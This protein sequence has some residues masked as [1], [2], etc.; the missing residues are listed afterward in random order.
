[1]I[2]DCHVHLPSPSQK[3]NFEWQPFAPDLTAANAEIVRIAVEQAPF[4]T[5]ACLIN[6]NFGGFCLDEMRRC[7][8]QYHIAWIGC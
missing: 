7:H 2:F 3:L 1:M 4:I 8:A 6:P 5:P